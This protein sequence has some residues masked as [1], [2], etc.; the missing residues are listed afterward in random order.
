VVG[1]TSPLED[2]LIYIASLDGG[3]HVRQ[4]LIGIGLDLAGT[5]AEDRMLWAAISVRDE[6]QQSEEMALTVCGIVV[7]RPTE[8]YSDPPIRLD[9]VDVI[10][11]VSA[12]VLTKEPKVTIWPTVVGR[13]R[14][15]RSKR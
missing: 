11:S 5:L 6:H 14:K 3:L 9:Q 1:L 10:V 8:Q 4:I 12:K 7:R 2:L 15:R 13:S